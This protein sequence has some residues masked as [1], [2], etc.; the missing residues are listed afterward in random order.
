[1]TDSPIS[2]AEPDGPAGAPVGGEVPDAVRPERED[3]R[4]HFAEDQREAS[5]AGQRR[6]QRAGQVTGGGTPQGFY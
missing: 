3:Q 4:N 5:G 1:M 2:G 6:D